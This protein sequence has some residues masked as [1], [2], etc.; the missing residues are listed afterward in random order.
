MI[1]KDIIEEIS[2]RKLLQY[3]ALPPTETSI[4]DMVE[5]D[6]K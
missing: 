1:S 4:L 6:Q 2:I 5:M 3:A